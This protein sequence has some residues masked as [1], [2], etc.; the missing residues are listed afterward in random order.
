MESPAWAAGHGHPVRDEVTFSVADLRQVRRITAQWAAQ[1]GLPDDRAD[2]FVIAVNEIATNAV[3][4]GSPVARLL[5]RTEGAA[6][7][8]VAEIG[9]TG[10][11]QPGPGPPSGDGGMGL[12]LARLICDEVDIRA[13]ESGTT[14][15]LRMNLPPRQRPA[16]PGPPSSAGSG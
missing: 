11:W 14:V 6:A 3:R 15:V 9:D 5:L 4:H 13:Q 7:V 10:C 1:A 8:A 2:D 12:P 16:E